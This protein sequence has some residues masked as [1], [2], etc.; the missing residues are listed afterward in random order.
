MPHA[1]ILNVVT[2]AAP[3]CVQPGTRDIPVTVDKDGNVLTLE[4]CEQCAQ[5]GVHT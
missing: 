2:C 1:Q 3:D 5:R 4:F